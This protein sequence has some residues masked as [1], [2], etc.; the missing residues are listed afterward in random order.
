MQ[1]ITKMVQEIL[2]D[3][4]PAM[5]LHMAHNSNESRL[6]WNAVQ[7]IQDNVQLHTCF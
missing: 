7:W 6:C 1:Q 5:D 2:D 3:Y 4:L